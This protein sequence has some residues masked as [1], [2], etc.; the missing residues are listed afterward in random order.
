M[1]GLVVPALQENGKVQSDLRNA[2]R[3]M[4]LHIHHEEARQGRVVGATTGIP[5]QMVRCVLHARLA[6]SDRKSLDLGLNVLIVQLAPFPGP[7]HS[8]SK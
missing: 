6:N 1:P 8:N 5:V 7:L 2:R 4:S 3:V